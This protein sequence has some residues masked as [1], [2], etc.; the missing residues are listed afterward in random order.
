MNDK[1]L[2]EAIEE[3]DEEYFDDESDRFSKNRSLKM[4]FKIRKT[5][6]QRAD[7]YSGGF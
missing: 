3:Q 2:F 5:E 6:I 4:T 7:S 1:K